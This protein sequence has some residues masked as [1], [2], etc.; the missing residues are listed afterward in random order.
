MRICERRAKN[1]TR[2]FPELARLET[3]EQRVAVYNLAQFSL[4]WRRHAG[5]YFVLVLVLVLTA[6]VIMFS[7]LMARWRSAYPVIWIGLGA[8][9]LVWGFDWYVVRFP[10]RRAIRAELNRRSL[11]VCM[12][13]AYDLTGNTSG[14]CP[15]CGIEAQS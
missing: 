3:S 8:G 4:G 6:A 7:G 14:V 1:L 5:T 10:T 11:P 12:R 13:C 9:A 15:E 2:R